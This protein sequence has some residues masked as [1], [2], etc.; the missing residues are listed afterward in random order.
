MLLP[1]AEATLMALVAALYLYD[2][3]LLLYANE[4]VLMPKRGGRWVLRLGSTLRLGGR[5]V[6][7]PSPLTLHRP[8]FRLAWGIEPAAPGGGKAPDTTWSARRDAFRPLAPLVWTMAAA[9]FVLLPLGLFSRFGERM[10]LAALVLLYA[11]I[12]VAI[13]W[14]AARRRS[15]GLAPKRLAALGFEALVCSPFALNLVRKVSA[16]LRIGEDLVDAARR[17]QGADDWRES[18]ALLAARLEGD[19]LEEDE[20]LMRRYRDRLTEE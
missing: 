5:E 10:L 13:A 14:L 20:A 3:A 16:E 4:G 6:Y 8:L 7:V 12:A 11:S 15:L 1:G 9:L 17:L 2:S 18:R 19:S